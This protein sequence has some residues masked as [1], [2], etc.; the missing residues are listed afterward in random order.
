MTG[1]T[2]GLDVG[3]TKI[4]GALID[5]AG[6]VL[7]RRTVASPASD[8]DAIVASLARLVEELSPSDSRPAVGAACAGYLDAARETVRFAPN[9]AWRDFPLRQLLADATGHDVVIENDADAAAYGELICGAAQGSDD[10]VMVTL[11]TGVGGAVVHGG[12]VHRGAFGIG[13]ELGHVRVEREGRLCGCGNRGCLESY[14]SGTALLA[15]AREAVASG[16]AGAA[17]L[18]DVC[19]GDVS[20]LSGHDVSRLAADGDVL[21]VELLADVGRWLGEGLA[22]VAAV[23]DPGL[24]VVGGG[25]SATGELVLGPARAAYAQHL[26]G[27]AHRPVA[28]MVLAQLGNDAGM[29]GAAALAREE[30]T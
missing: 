27:G 22:T 8:P 28:D 21:S 6:T 11:G 13:G 1:P 5:P 3:G 20:A 25:L 30:R 23:V 18:S 16:A 9:L 19:D 14:S 2:I 4:A 26:T 7:V 15:R 29:I 24:I 12:R 10:L 17:A